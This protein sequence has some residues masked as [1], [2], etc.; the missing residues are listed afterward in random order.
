MATDVDGEVSFPGVQTRIEQVD[1]IAGFGVD[2]CE[3]GAF[4]E[5]ALRATPGEIVGM[6]ITPVDSR[7]DGGDVK[8]P[9]IGPVWQ[10]AVLAA[11]PG[12]LADELRA[13]SRH[14][15]ALCD[16]VQHGDSL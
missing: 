16:V 5:L 10:A 14:G 2:A 9:F 1:A 8:G 13:P 6:I 7:H 3:V 4:V 15:A 11:L 12:S